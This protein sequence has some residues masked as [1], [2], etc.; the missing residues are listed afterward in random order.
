MGQ[1]VGSAPT[2]SS[3]IY[4]TMIMS[5]TLNQSW[6]LTTP[7]GGAEAVL[8]T[9]W[10]NLAILVSRLIVVES[11]I[12]SILIPAKLCDACCSVQ[13]QRYHSSAKQRSLG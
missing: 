13:G 3:K 7:F 11:N 10:P 4:L 8:F 9:Y 1:Q 6:L 5:M 12:S 2:K